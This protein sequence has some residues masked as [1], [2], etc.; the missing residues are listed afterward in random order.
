PFPSPLKPTQTNSPHPTPASHRLHITQP[1]PQLPKPAPSP[2][3]QIA[4]NNQTFWASHISLT[5]SIGCR[6]WKSQR[7]L[8]L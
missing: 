7:S 2:T 1:P 5:K 8:G 3:N 4:Q 6:S